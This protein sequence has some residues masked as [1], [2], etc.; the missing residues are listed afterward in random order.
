MLKKPQ[1]NPGELQAAQPISGKQFARFNEYNEC[2][3]VCM[4]GEFFLSGEH[5]S[6]GA[7]LTD[8]LSEETE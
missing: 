7:R 4:H 2:T 8:V 3:C 6:Y 5:S 1:R